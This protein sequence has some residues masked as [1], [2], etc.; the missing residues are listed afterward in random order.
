MIEIEDKN[1][2]V[3]LKVID[4]LK[5]DMDAVQDWPEYANY[6]MIK[7]SMLVGSYADNTKRQLWN[8]IDQ[9]NR[10]NARIAMREAGVSGRR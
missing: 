4:M 8:F 2:R 3:T 10:Y 1:V 9:T 6:E 5:H 7:T